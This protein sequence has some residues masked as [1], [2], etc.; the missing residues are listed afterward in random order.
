MMLLL[1][2][3]LLLWAAG[4]P[5]RLG[6]DARDLLEDRGNTLVFSAVSILEVSI[7][8][9]LGKQS[10]R[11]DPALLRRGLLESGYRE[12]SI[13]SIHALAVAE[14][15]RLHRDPFDRM[16]IAQAR[17]EGFTLLTRDERVAA[18]GAPTTRI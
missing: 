2:T 18:Y 13:T 11:V 4:S 9:A 16:L 10:F 8:S 12:L 15:P 1:D 14:L 7:K 6:A 5:E 17:A 3:H